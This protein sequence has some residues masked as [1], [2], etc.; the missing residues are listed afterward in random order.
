MESRLSK[1]EE[2]VKLLEQNNNSVIYVVE[3]Y[4]SY[5]NI[6]KIVGCYS[7][8]KKAIKKAEKI[9]DWVSTSIDDLEN[10][11]EGKCL[12]SNESG[13]TYV[14]IYKFTINK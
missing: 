12:E 2:K 1:L 14:R 5:E 8:P 13:N 3:E 11:A 10:L 4:E 7:K 9:I 6:T